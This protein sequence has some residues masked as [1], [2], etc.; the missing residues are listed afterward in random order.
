MS[1]RALLAIIGAAAFAVLCAVG[2][3]SYWRGYLEG[4]WD[5][6]CFHSGAIDQTGHLTG[7]CI[8]DGKST[9]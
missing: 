4:A 2:Y 8:R 1:N 7:Q 6:I 5:E 9:L 3:A